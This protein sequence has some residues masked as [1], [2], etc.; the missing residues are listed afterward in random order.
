MKPL[1]SSDM[2]G[3]AAPLRGAILPS[4]SLGDPIPSNQRRSANPVRNVYPWLLL[5]S[6][7][8]ATVFC[9]LYITKPVIETTTVIPGSVGT[10]FQPKAPTLTAA[11]PKQT[12]E[13][14]APPAQ[15]QPISGLKDS[16][17]LPKATAALPKFEETNLGIQHVLTAQAPAGDLC[18]IVLDVPV[19]YQSR[20]LR[21]TEKDVAEARELL[22][23]LSSYQEKSVALRSEGLE[24]LDHWNRLVN[25][26]IPASELRA[27]S[28]ALPGNQKNS[29]LLIVPAGLNTQE[30]IQL[31]P[32][33]K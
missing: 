28:P 22:N 19:L 14:T 23:R 31:K 24:L 9:I 26:S 2:T 29:P 20:Q 15:G 27:D 33:E 10:P 30:S 1:P 4:L 17:A 13:A 6:T 7:T 25:R 8:I 3:K 12:P 16:A 32:S 11:E 5:A 21:W 18:R